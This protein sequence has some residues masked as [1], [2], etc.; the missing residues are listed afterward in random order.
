MFQGKRI[1]RPPIPSQQ[2]RSPGIPDRSESQKVGWL[3]TRDE[4]VIRP[5]LKEAGCM[6]GYYRGGGM[7]AV[8][9]GGALQRPRQ[10]S[11]VFW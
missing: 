5:G 10:T 1:P 6:A 9:G 11:Q 3:Q 2:V 7:G 8:R 4:A